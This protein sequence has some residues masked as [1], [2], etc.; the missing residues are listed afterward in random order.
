MGTAWNLTL[1]LG[2]IMSIG[3]SKE[4][5]STYVLIFSENIKYLEFLLRSDF[6]FSLKLFVFCKFQ[7]IVGFVD[8]GDL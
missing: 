8:I 6:V 5:V 4:S 1:R 2:Y 7:K 3:E